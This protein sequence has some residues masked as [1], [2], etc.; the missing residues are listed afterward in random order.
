MTRRKKK[1]SMGL[2]LILPA[3]VGFAL[4]YIV[5]FLWMLRYSFFQKSSFVGFEQYRRVLQN[6]LFCLAVENTVR[7][8]LVTLTLMLTISYLIALLLKKQAQRH[9]LLKSTLLLPYMMPVA[10]TVILVDTLFREACV[11]GRLCDLFHFPLQELLSGA[12]AF[13]V[14]V[15]LCLWKNTGYAVILLLSGLNV[16]PQGQYDTAELDGASSLQKFWY[17]T[18]PQM[19]SSVFFALVFSFINAF[20]CFREIFLIG[21]E[22]PDESL[23]ML[24]HYINNSFQNLNY[25]KLSVT[26]VL[27]FLAVLLLFVCFQAAMKRKGREL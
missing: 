23:Y 25:S 18:T 11:W 20:K 22:H 10:G 15:A 26:A 4:F 2:A 1:T 13:W 24:Q 9:S 27:I 12:G 21:G 14:V 19:W 6:D 5:P 8:L 3:I 16:I 17:I 7:F